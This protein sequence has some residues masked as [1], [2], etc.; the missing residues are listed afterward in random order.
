MGADA[1]GDAP[2]VPTKIPKPATLTELEPPA[3]VIIAGPARVHHPRT[4]RPEGRTAAGRRRVETLP[5]HR[6]TGCR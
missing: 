1:F 3:L 6:T 4:G 5:A 2:T